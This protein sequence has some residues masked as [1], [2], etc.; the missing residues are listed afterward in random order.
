[1]EQRDARV[2]AALE[3]AELAAACGVSSLYSKSVVRNWRSSFRDMVA[4]P[5]AARVTA[6][7]AA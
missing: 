3:E 7:G 5:G 1:V 2:A 6:A 4:A